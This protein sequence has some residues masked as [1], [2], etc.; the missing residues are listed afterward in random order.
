MHTILTSPDI[1]EP[2][3]E[4]SPSGYP[5]SDGGSSFQLM[6]TEEEEKAK[7]VKKKSRKYRGTTGKIVE[8][9]CG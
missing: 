4:I 7:E 6:K 9:G 8:G 2:A 1:L 3:I 5:S